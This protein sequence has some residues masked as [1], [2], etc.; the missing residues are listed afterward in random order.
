MNFFQT[1]NNG[2]AAARNLA[3]SMA[4]RDYVVF[5]DADDSIDS[6]QLIHALHLMSNLEVD[7]GKFPYYKNGVI[8]DTTDETKKFK[9]NDSTNNRWIFMK[10]LGYWRFIYKTKSVQN[11]FFFFPTFSQ[12]SGRKFILDDLFWLILLG[13]SKLEF[14]NSNQFGF[15]QYQSRK[16]IS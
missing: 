6:M 9:L 4:T 13:S 14:Y 15:Y 1:S 5:L 8:K 7:L 16:L 3:L 10:G 12:L 11:K 2:S